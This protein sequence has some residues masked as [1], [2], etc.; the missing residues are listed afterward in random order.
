MAQNL[1]YG[2]Y[3]TSV[4]DEANGRFGGHVID[5]VAQLSMGEP[6][7]VV[8]SVLNTCYTQSL[9][10]K[11]GV[12]SLSILPANVDPFVIAN[13]GFQCG[14]DV[15]KWENVP[16]TL[17]EGLP[18]LDEAVAWVK[19]QVID[20]RVMDTHMAFFCNPVAIEALHPDKEPL[21]Y[22]DYFTKLKAPA[23]AAFQER[24]A[25]MK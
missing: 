14:R 7:T 20:K 9:I 15:S 16:H 6:P 23:M 3:V 12:F 1:T 17:R 8:A 5:A 18:A 13:F 22:A 10:E 19:F 21:R 25:G 11:E 4:W 2:L 24:Q